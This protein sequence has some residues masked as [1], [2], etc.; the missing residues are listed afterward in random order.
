MDWLL[1]HIR[2]RYW[3]L[4]WEIIK[5]DSDNSEC[6]CGDIYHPA[7]HARESKR[8]PHWKKVHCSSLKYQQRRWYSVGDLLQ[9]QASVDE[10]VESGC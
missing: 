4:D 8:P 10:G 5:Y 7:S 9:D 2:A 1:T 6:N 3:E